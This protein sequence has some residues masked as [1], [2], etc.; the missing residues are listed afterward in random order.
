VIVE[1][2]L[3]HTPSGDDCGPT[4]VSVVVAEIG[5]HAQRSVQLHCDRTVVTLDE[6]HAA[7]LVLA[8]QAAIAEVQARAVSL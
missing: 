4:H 8:L 7:A 5:H 1:A 6:N 2:R 3:M